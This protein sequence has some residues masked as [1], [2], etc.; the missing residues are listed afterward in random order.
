VGIKEGEEE[1][2][3]RRKGGKGKGGKRGGSCTPTEVFKVGA[4][5]CG[6]G[7]CLQKKI[8]T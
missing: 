5:A 3:E 6:F 2:E 4:Y 8:G 1:G 7:N